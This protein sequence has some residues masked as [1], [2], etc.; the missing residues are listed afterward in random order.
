M[1]QQTLAY[2]LNDGAVH[3]ALDDH[4]IEPVAAIVARRIAD[5]RGRAGFGID[6]D[7][8]DMTAIW[9]GLRRIGGEPGVEVLDDFAALP[10]LLGACRKIEQADAPV[11]AGD[12]KC[13]LLIHDV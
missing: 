4:V 10:A 2:P 9:K 11:G 1:P 13:A 8:S 12:D 5:Q 7:F 6:L 3:L